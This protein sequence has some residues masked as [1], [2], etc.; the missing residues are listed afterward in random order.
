M[1]VAWPCTAQGCETGAAAS[2]W[3]SSALAVIAIAK[4][5][6]ANPRRGAPDR[7]RRNNASIMVPPDKRL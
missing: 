7:I 6:A 2:P 5:H 3:P 4:S 1:N